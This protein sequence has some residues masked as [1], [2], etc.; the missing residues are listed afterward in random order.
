M[1]KPQTKKSRQKKLWTTVSLYIRQRDSIDGYSSC[2]TCGVS[3]PW[4]EMDAGHFVPKTSKAIQYD[5]R[6]IH[7]Q[8]PRCNR[9]MSGNIHAYFINMEQRYGRETVDELLSFRG[10]TKKWTDEEIE[11]LTEYYKNKLKSIDSI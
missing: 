5:E 4:K 8:C 6:N 1:P 10:Q 7:S 11:E 2:F 9:Y 3:K